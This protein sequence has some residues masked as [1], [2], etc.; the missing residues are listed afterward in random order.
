MEKITD[1]TFEEE[2][3]KAE[4]TVAI[5]FGATWCGPCKKLDPIMEDLAVEYDGR[6]K[7]RKVDVGEAPGI[8]QNYR[9]LSVPQV[10]FFNGGKVV[11]AVIGLVNK[12]KLVELF[13]KH[14]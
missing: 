8:A 6:I 13:E 12:P 3:L 2:V 9:V 1:A 7:V 10:L 4:G 11:D 14:C 5:D